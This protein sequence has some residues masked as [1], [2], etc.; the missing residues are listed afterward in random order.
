V[1]VHVSVSCRWTAEV[2]DAETESDVVRQREIFLARCF[3]VTCVSLLF[4]VNLATYINRSTSSSSRSSRQRRVRRR[5]HDLPATGG[6]RR[7]RRRGRRG[8]VRP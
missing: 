7:P 8:I 3:V 1:L 2:K 5:E 4:V 6:R